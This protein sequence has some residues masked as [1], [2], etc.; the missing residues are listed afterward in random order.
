MSS[1]QLSALILWEV[2]LVD[3]VGAVDVWFPFVVHFTSRNACLG[4]IRMSNSLLKAYK[5][6]PVL[7]PILYKYYKA[8]LERRV[9]SRDSSVCLCNLYMA[10]SSNHK[11]LLHSITMIYL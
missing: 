1:R 2:L 3:Q 10:L 6:S 5:M 7:H 11:M 9:M 4:L 8:S